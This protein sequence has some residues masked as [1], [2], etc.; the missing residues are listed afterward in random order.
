VLLPATKA[1]C[2]SRDATA[3]MPR[4]RRI[5]LVRPCGVPAPGRP[6][7]GVGFGFGGYHQTAL[8]PAPSGVVL[9]EVRT[10]IW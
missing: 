8:A 10:V 2:A 5:V 4:G 1:S 6:G 3:L 9:D 7:F